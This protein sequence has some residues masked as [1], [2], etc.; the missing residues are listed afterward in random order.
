M[1]INMP[2]IYCIL[3]FMN[4]LTEYQMNRMMLDIHVLEKKHLMYHVF[5]AVFRIFWIAVCGCLAYPLPIFV[6]GLFLLLF[7][8]ILPYR[9]R[10]LLMTNFIMIIFLLFTSF[11]MLVIGCAGLVGYSFPILMENT[12]IRITVLCTAFLLHDLI[13]FLLIRYRPGF[14]WNEEFDRLKVVIY[15][16]FLSVCVLYHLIDSIVL[17]VY[18]T[19]H[20]NYL[21]LLSGD[22]LIL[23]LMF[24]FLNS[25]HIFL[26]SEMMKKQYEESEVLV[27]QQFFEKEALKELSGHDPLTSAYN[28]REICTIMQEQLKEGHKLACAFVDL[29]GLK[30]TNDTYGHTFGDRMLKKFADACNLMLKDKGCLA[31]IGGDEFLLVFFDRN[32]SDIEA[33]IKH[34][35]LQLIENKSVEEKIYFSY[36]ISFDEATVDAYITSADRKMYQCKKR[37][38][39]GSL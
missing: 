18:E 22:V 20:I 15:T 13:C 1:V 38:R 23:I 6:I 21:L 28:R 29:D 34:L 37:K 14:L 32:I 36:G 31:R 12:A 10:L 19:I 11:L 35:Q 5:C 4:C 27:A 3:I 9:T 30:R 33:D 7:I 25:N 17:S 8:N 24:M 2:V 39:S 16:L 26:K